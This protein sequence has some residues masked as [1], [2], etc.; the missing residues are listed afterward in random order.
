MSSSPTVNTYP[1]RDPQVV[2]AAEIGLVPTAKGL[3]LRSSSINS[4]REEQNPKR[5]ILS[6]ILSSARDFLRDFIYPGL[7]LHTRNRASLTQFWRKGARDVLDAGSGNGYFSW[8]AYKT[9]ARVVALNFDKQQ[10][11]K[12]RSF[13]I[14]HKGAD[15]NRLS[16]EHRNLY[17]LPHETRAFHEIICFEVLEHIR[18]HHL[19][20]R[21]FFRVLR[22]GGVLHLC[23]PNP[24]HPTHAWPPGTP[25]PPEDGGH[26]RPGYTEQDYRDLLE[27][28]GFEIERLVGI[29]PSALCRA[30]DILRNLR[31]ALP[32]IALVPVFPC[33]LPTV[34]FAKLN[35]E[36][37][38]S[39]YVQAR[40][41]A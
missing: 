33:F 35:P 11:E 3:L 30:D 29:G 6:A 39:L 4:R 9:G 7:D 26:V 14:G 37:P 24:R 23:C 16:F 15:P 32:E 36:V 17:D 21:E 18:D 41:P 2:R 10:A 28:I 20:A 27:P 25:E 38:F 40:K 31:V 13:L 1:C 12:A 22:P 34:W 8:L 5:A 19:I